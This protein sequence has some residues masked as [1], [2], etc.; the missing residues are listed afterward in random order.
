MVSGTEIGQRLL[1]L[2]IAPVH[3]PSML[4]AAVP[5]LASLI[6]ITMYYARY[7]QEEQGWESAVGNT[8]VL[9]FVSIDLIRYVYQ[10]P[11]VEDIVRVAGIPLPMKTFAAALVLLEGFSLLVITYN[12]MLTKRTMHAVTSPLPVNLT[13][14]VAMSV[15]YSDIPLDLTTLLAA[16]ALFIV[17]YIPI[18]LATKGM[19][20]L[21]WLGKK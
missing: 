19:P 11:Q 17:A 1:D 6:I 12:H 5:L 2:V 4:W 10:N 14:Y 8:L 3:N 20:K 18:R 15:V 21:P 16:L 7:P 9:V 13:A